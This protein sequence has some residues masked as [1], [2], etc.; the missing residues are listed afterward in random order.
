VP[1]GDFPT[2]NCTQWHTLF[3]TLLSGQTKPAIIKQLLFSVSAHHPHLNPLPSR[4]RKF[5]LHNIPSLQRRGILAGDEIPDGG[6]V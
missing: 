2:R 6:K 1:V 3:L 4:E 5:G